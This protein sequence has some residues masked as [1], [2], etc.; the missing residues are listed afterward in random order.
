MVSNL[1]CIGYRLYSG[2]R[3]VVTGSGPN[4]N[5][6]DISSNKIVASEGEKLF[7]KN[8]RTVFTK[9][10]RQKL[11]FSN[12]AWPLNWFWNGLFFYVFHSNF[13]STT[14][15]KVDFFYEL[16]WY[17]MFFLV[18]PWLLKYIQKLFLCNHCD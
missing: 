5:Q 7:G 18:S 16:L 12:K 14:A 13:I 8:I 9:F 4:F 10:L 1:H 2:N 11:S 3:A 15:I 17:P 6:F